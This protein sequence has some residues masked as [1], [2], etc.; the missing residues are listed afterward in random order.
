MDFVRKDKL[1]AYL[2][3][4]IRA[5]DDAREEFKTEFQDIRQN[6]FKDACVNVKEFVEILDTVRVE[7]ELE[8][9][10]VEYE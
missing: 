10:G 3:A 9:D 1:V 5:S 2:E 6:G 8:F 4:L 7:Q